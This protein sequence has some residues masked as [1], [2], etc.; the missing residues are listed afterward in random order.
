MSD[1]AGGTARAGDVAAPGSAIAVVVIADAPRAGRVLGALEP[2]LGAAGCARLQA[3]LI[4]RAA[5]WALAA[6]AP[7]AAY[8]AFAP[9]DAGPELAVLVPAGI[10][11]FAQVEG[12]L[13]AR[14]EDAFR[15]AAAGSGLPVA[16]VDAHVPTLGANHAWA[17]ADDLADGVDVTFGPGAEGG[18]YLLGAR[19]PQAAVF[20]IDPDAWGTDRLLGLSLEASVAAG[21]S[22]GWLRSERGLQTPAD[23]AALLADPATPADVRAALEGGTA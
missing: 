4:V 20:E 15:H 21:L 13:G 19:E 9:A 7:G 11:L 2:L 3:A 1:E 14:L 18:F 17:V 23:V 16:L 5:R 6:A 8:L 12:S 22:I 10:E